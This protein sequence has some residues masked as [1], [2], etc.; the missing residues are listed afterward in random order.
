MALTTAVR[1]SGEDL[2]IDDVWAVA[3]DGAPAAI[4]RVDYLMRGVLLGPGVHRVRFTYVPHALE[5]GI[6]I[7][8]LSFALTLLLAGA[9]LFLR[10]RAA[11]A[12]ATP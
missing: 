2:K 1:L 11:R 4:H 6:R 5:A 3:V 10:R 12:G 9:G 7:S 8:A